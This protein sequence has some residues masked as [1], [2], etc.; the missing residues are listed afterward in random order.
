[1]NRIATST[2]SST[3]HPHQCSDQRGEYAWRSA[4]GIRAPLRLTCYITYETPHT[5]KTRHCTH[6]ARAVSPALEI[7]PVEDT[8][9]LRTLNGTGD[10]R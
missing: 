6:A 7:S 8:E 4:G 2:S 3:C 10:M 5:S 1:M 9:L